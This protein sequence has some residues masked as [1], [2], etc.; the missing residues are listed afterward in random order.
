VSVG[1]SQAHW[2]HPADAPK[3]PFSVCGAAPHLSLSLSLPPSL[4]PSL[5]PPFSVML[6]SEARA[7]CMLGQHCTMSLSSNPF[8]SLG[9]CLKPSLFSFPLYLCPPFSYLLAS[10]LQHWELGLNMSHHSHCLCVCVF[11]HIYVHTY[12]CVHLLLFPTYLYCK[13]IYVAG[14]YLER[15]WNLIS[16]KYVYNILLILKSILTVLKASYNLFIPEAS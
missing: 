9:Q 16:W 5:S 11:A 10:D 8:F 15:W 1:D 14:T 13:S 12:V 3:L 2:L 7:L 4:P 6:R